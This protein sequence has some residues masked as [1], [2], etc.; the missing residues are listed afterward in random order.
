MRVVLLRSESPHNLVFRVMGRTGFDLRS[1]VIDQGF[2]PL[3]LCR[4]L[5]LSALRILPSV[6]APYG[7][8]ALVDGHDHA[9]AVAYY[10]DRYII[11]IAYPC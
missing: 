3:P 6:K 8:P 1:F 10:C 11:P 9:R 2:D 5:H 7:K 4:V